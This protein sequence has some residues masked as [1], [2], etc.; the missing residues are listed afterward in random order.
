MPL[1]FSIA[2]EKRSACTAV[3]DRR[4]VDLAARV[5]LRLRQRRCLGLI[6]VRAGENR[7]RREAGERAVPAERAALT[8]EAAVVAPAIRIA[9]RSDLRARRSTPF[10][11]PPVA[12]MRA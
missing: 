2:V 7:L 4:R 9:S 5:E 1:S 11:K 6:D 3:R 8:L 10:V 12:S